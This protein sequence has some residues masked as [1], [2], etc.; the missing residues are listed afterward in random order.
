MIA[1]RVIVIFEL[2]L[3]FFAFVFLVYAFLQDRMDG[4]SYSGMHAF[5]VYVFSYIKQ[6]TC[7]AFMH[8]IV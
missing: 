2:T 8:M 7:R 1:R 6:A 5:M 3:F 4:F